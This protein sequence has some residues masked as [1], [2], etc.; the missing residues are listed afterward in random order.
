M[1]FL[2]TAVEVWRGLERKERFEA[3]EALWSRS[4][5]IAEAVLELAQL[6][7]MRPPSVLK[8]PR[9]RRVAALAGLVRPSESV[10]LSLLAALHLA[11]RRPLL[12]AFLEALEIPHRDGL[13][14]DEVKLQLPELSRIVE[15]GLSLIE[16]F[17]IEPVKTYWTTLWL[18]DREVWE[19]L[20]RAWAEIEQRLGQQKAPG[21]DLHSPKSMDSG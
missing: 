10:A 8:T 20:H 19:P 5:G 14:S 11:K 6:W 7:R 13:L 15:V 12:I 4:D 21:S 16:K 17:G 9:E 18:Q 1:S 2:P 3:S